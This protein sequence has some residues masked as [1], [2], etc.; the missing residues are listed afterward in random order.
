MDTTRYFCTYFDH[1]YLSRG[2]AL[3]YSLTQ[4]C[5]SF[6]LWVL[7]LSSECYNTLKELNLPNLIPISQE[8][9]EHGDEK[10]VAAKDNRSK[11][12]YYFTCTPSLPL[13]ILNHFPEVDLIT[14]LD[15]DLFFF[16]NPQPIFDEIGNGSIAI[17]PH[18]FSNHL[19]RY[20]RNG[21]YNVGWV[22]FRRDS[23][24]IACLEWWREKC[25]DWC[26]DKIEP[27]RFADQK[28]L[29]Y[30]ESMF[31]G[32]IVIQNKGSN[33]A[34]WNISNYT[35]EFRD[36]KV[37]ADDDYLIFFHFDSFKKVAPNIYTSSMKSYVSV[38]TLLIRNRIFNPYIMVLELFAEY[39]N[40]FNGMRKAQHTDLSDLLQKSSKTLM[41]NILNLITLNYFFVPK[42][43]KDNT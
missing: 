20:E 5:S 24:G 14:Y 10:L 16:S 9:F 8:D 39:N 13:Y 37:W 38:V 42:S 3:H 12:E 17:I 21:I 25:I 1:Y 26:Y 31:E 34:A 11:I 40:S 22:S 23:N 2:L 35:L 7:C 43:N 19:K 27:D 6:T 29:N 15:S 36:G 28:Y 41:E 32:V 30:W 18:R 33:L 4:H